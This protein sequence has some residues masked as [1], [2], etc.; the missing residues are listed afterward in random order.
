[1]YGAESLK[2]L[3]SKHPIY[4]T[5]LKISFRPFNIMTVENPIAPQIRGVEDSGRVKALLSQHDI[6]AGLLGIP[7]DGITGYMPES[8]RA[9][10]TQLL[11]SLK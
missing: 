4:G 11:G 7:T 5:D 10:M 8:A 3:P 2:H 1:M 6:T 9:L